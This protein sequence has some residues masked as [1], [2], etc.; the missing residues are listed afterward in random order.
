[1]MILCPGPIVLLPIYFLNTRGIRGFLSIGK[2]L[3]FLVVLGVV[4]VLAELAG[5][6]LMD[7]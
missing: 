3:V 4:M 2:A 6:A 1:M 7:R 5:S